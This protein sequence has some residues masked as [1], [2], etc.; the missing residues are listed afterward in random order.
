MIPEEPRFLFSAILVAGNELM[1]TAVSWR[2]YRNG[3]VR[4][5]PK[6]ESV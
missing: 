4:R 2:V 5:G 6:S 3:V 1:P